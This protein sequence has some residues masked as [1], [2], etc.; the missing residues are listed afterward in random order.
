MFEFLANPKERPRL[1]CAFVPSAFVFDWR[2][3]P[4]TQAQ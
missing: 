4:K 2:D 1:A 3:M